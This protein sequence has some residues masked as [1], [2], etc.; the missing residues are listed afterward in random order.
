[1][2]VISSLVA[3]SISLYSLHISQTQTDYSIRHTI[4]QQ[5]NV[6]KNAA[7][8]M[9]LFEIESL[10]DTLGHYAFYYN[11]YYDLKLGDQNVILPPHVNVTVFITSENDTD[12]TPIKMEINNGK[13]DVAPM[14]IIPVYDNGTVTRVSPDLL[15]TNPNGLIE[16]FELGKIRLPSPLYNEHGMY[17][18][19]TKDI[20]NFNK[21]VAQDLYTFYN[22]VRIAESDRVYIQ[23]YLDAHPNVND[24]KGAYFDS[25]MQMRFYIINAN[26]MVPRILQE[27]D[28]ETKS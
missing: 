7:A 4:E 23:T 9:F 14:R 13:I 19:Y 20:S 21:T 1:M 5:N 28:N 2:Y 18:L 3:I 26:L 25:Y 6:S 12:A 10:N 15:I 22:E 11:N 16:F 24:L 27:L 8:E 17:Y